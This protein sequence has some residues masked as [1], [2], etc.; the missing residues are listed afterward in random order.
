VIAAERLPAGDP[1]RE[2]VR[3]QI[4]AMADELSTALLAGEY[5]GFGWSDDACDWEYVGNTL[6]MEKFV[7]AEIGR[8]VDLVGR[9]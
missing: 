1:R 7:Q 9:L 2:V 3:H 6:E 4:Q 8:L 5:I